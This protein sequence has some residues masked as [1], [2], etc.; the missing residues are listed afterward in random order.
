MNDRAE[1]RIALLLAQGQA[2][3]L[4]AQLAI[5]EARQQLA[6]LRAVATALGAV[7]GIAGSGRTP[8]SLAGAVAKFGLGHPWLVSFAASV[9]L[10]LLRRRP[11]TWAAAAAGIAAWWLLRP[12]PARTPPGRTPG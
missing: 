6:P 7:L 4:G 3:R 12:S 9:L 10:R 5:L 8:S 2:Q 1:D 11:L